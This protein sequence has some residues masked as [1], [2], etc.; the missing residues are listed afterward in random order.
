MPV[1]VA[2][3]HP[4]IALVKYWGKRDTALNL[5]AVP[6]LSLTVAR[7]HTRTRVSWGATADEVHL[8]GAVAS[9]AETGRVLRLLDAMFPGR[10]PV[11][12]DTANHFP[13]GAGLA[14]SSS[15]FAALVVAAAA[16]AGADLSREA[17]SVWAHRGSGSACRSLW[18]GFV[19]WKLG[20]RADGSDSHAHPVG[21]S[22]DL[23]LVV[24]IVSGR[25]KAIGSTEAM[26]RTRD[27]SPYWDAWVA[28]AAAD[29]DAARAA[30][31]ARDLEALG[32]VTERSFLKM[33]ATM[34]TASP[35]VLY[36]EP[37]SVACFAAVRELR[38]KG[39]GAWATMDAGPN[40]KVL[41]RPD[42]AR[43]VADTL[44]ASCDRVEILEPGTGAHLDLRAPLVAVPDG[45]R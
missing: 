39:I 8:D 3:A 36:R 12:V 32:V 23:R 29:V 15:G 37:A 5:P 7:F 16:A 4:N 9:A 14:S 41:C 34:E 24:A 18:G 10:P 17:L 19:E 26:V 1:A 20:E 25:K 35:P 44:L 31:L 22:W 38:A 27:T 43:L 21:D 33:F 40:V 28:T 30:V 45:S 13:T 2:V 11:L 6:S 42:D